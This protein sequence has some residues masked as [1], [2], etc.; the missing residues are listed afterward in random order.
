MRRNFLAN[1]AARFN[2]LLF[3]FRPNIN[4]PGSVLSLLELNICVY[5]DALY[6]SD[7]VRHS[8]VQYAF[9]KM[10]ADSTIMNSSEALSPGKQATLHP[11]QSLRQ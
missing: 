9:W 7:K 11:P 1:V 6:P 2:S 4:A 8:E 3:Y 5:S 10:N